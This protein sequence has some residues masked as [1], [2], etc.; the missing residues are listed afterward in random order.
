MSNAAA[1]LVGNQLG[2]KN[3]EVVYYQALGI[4]I[5]CFLTSIVVAIF[6]YF[7]QTPILNAFSACERKKRV[8]SLRSL[9]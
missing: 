9:F 4:T 5:L 7:V 8:H 3:N 6:L 1:V 2:A